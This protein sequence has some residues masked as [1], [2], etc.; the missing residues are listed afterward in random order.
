MELHC[1][2]ELELLHLGFQSPP[3]TPAP[4]ARP[5]FPNIRWSGA[6]AP[7]FIFIVLFKVM[8]GECRAELAA[9]SPEVCVEFF[10]GWRPIRGL[11]QRVLMACQHGLAPARL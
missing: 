2:N 6:M 1:R 9:A 8:G 5:G 7:C 10:Q 11:R 3:T 4:P